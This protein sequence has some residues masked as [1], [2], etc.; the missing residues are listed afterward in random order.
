[1]MGSPMCPQFFFFANFLFI[2][3]IYFLQFSLLS[4]DGIPE[5]DLEKHSS[6]T[7]SQKVPKQ[8]KQ[9]VA[10]QPPSQGRKWP[11]HVSFLKTPNFSADCSAC[12][13]T[14]NL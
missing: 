3:F 5:V 9:S 2:L 1:M 11:W 7:G 12:E 13:S 6:P 10:R 4:A 14:F 8:E